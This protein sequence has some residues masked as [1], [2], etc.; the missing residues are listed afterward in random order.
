LVVLAGEIDLTNV[1]DLQT[2]VDN[3]IKTIDGTV[4]IDLGDVTYIGSTGLHVLLTASDQLRQEQRRLVV[5]RASQQ[6]CGCSSSAALPHT[7][8]LT[9]RIANSLGRV[10]F[11]GVGTV[12]R[13]AVRP[14]SRGN[15]GP[16]RSALARGTGEAMSDAQHE[17]RPESE[18]IREHEDI[19]AET[20]VEDVKELFEPD[21]DQIPPPSPDA[22]PP[23]D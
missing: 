23:E 22:P 21:N 5:T 19:D 17:P 10:E 13:G 7:S 2:L 9:C 16:V 15:R 18:A 4:K 11:L 14:P 1:V 6:V 20:V 12:V 3:A 8:C